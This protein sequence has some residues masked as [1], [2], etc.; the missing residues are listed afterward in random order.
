MRGERA[1]RPRPPFFPT[2]FPT[3]L[4]PLLIGAATFA[5]PAAG[6]SRP[7]IDIEGYRFELTLRDD[8][9]E[10]AGRTTVTL[11]FTADG[12]TE[13]PLDLIG[14]ADDGRGMEVV[15][16]TSA[17]GAATLDHRHEDDLLTIHLPE[18][19]TAGTLATFTVDYRGVPA[20]GLR[21]GPNKYGERTFFSDNWPNRARNWLPTVDHIGDKAACEFVV[22]APA[23]YQV[24]S[25]GRPRRGDRHRRRDAPYPLEAVRPDHRGCTWWVWPASPSPRLSNCTTLIPVRP[26]T[27]PRLSRAAALLSSY[28]R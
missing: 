24:V 8:T 7:G 4:I 20:S 22:T 9:D 19:G 10:I 13:V 26:P 27:P 11:R 17:D 6:P 12:V 21:V 2:A 15:A 16:V 18:P 28:S 23:H 25:N 5:A 3:L 14:R 1:T